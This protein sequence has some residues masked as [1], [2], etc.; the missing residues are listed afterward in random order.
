LTFG[1]LFGQKGFETRSEIAQPGTGTAA[2]AWDYFGQARIPLRRLINQLDRNL[3]RK[4]RIGDVLVSTGT[5][6]K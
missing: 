5:R 3:L 6:P 2:A 1:L 4:R